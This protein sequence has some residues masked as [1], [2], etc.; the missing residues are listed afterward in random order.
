MISFLKTVLII[1]LV[2][3]GLKYLLK[4]LSPY[5]MRY[6]ARKASQRFEQAFGQHPFQQTPYTDGDDS[7]IEKKP[8]NPK[9]NGK[10]VGEYVDFEEID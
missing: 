1:L 10:I 9:G 8:K 3:L 4:W 5:I 7:T 6:V 2:Y